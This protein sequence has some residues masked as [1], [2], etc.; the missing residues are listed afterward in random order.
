MKTHL[1]KE[2]DLPGIAQNAL[3]TIPIGSRF[4]QHG[5]LFDFTK[6]AGAM[7]TEAEIL[8]D[9]AWVSLTLKQKKGSSIR[10][11]KEI[12]AD[13]IFDI[14]NKYPETSKSGYTY[15][16]CL[17]IP[18]TRTG[19]GML[20][21]PFALVIGMLDIDHYIVNVKFKDVVPTTVLVGVIP[22]IDRG[23]KRPLGEHI[24]LEKSER[25][26]TTISVENVTELPFGEPNTAMLG[27]HIDLGA[28][29][30]CDDVEVR[31]NEEL[32][33]DPLTIAQNNYLLHR[34]GRSPQSGWFDVDFNRKGSALPV[35]VAT[36]FRQKFNWSTAPNAYEVYSE[37]VYNMGAANYIG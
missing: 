25:S 3:C 32:L 30:V 35:G 36:S 2:A 19:L 7:M 22:E 28:T 24:R 21:D 34:A 29:G 9:V 4:N 18:F 37:M 26:H 10:L 31:F 17:Y 13:V 27:Y 23:P 5:L 14:L 33:H 1:A 6:A 20:V 16:G 8:A 11:L 12:P 15:A